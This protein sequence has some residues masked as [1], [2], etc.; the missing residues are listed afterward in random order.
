MIKTNSTCTY[1]KILVNEYNMI[2]KNL[3]ISFYTKYGWI[4]LTSYI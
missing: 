2:T 4:K 1:C 3:N